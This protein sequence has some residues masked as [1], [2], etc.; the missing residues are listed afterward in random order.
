MEN[1]AALE[2]E[3]DV[4]RSASSLLAPST[5]AATLFIALLWFVLCRA[6]SVEWSG[7]EQYSYGWFVPFFAAYLFWLR[8]EDRPAP[9]SAA[10]GRV[11][12]VLLAL[13]AGL[14]VALLPVRAFEVVAPDWRPLAWLHACIVVALTLLLLWRA[15]GSRWVRHFA[16]PVA[17]ILVAV[18]W[19]ATLETAVVQGLMRIVAAIAAESLALFGVPAQ[20][21][22]NLLRLRTGL[23]GVDEACS[24]VRSLQ[25]SFM[26]GLLFGELHRLR[27]LQRI[28][29]LALAA[30]VAFVGNVCRAFFLVWVAAQHGI[31]A[32]ERWHDLTGFSIVIIVFLGTMAAASLL[33]RKKEEGGASVAASEPVRQGGRERCAGAAIQPLPVALACVWILLVEGGVEAWYRYHERG[34]VA[35]EKWTVQWPETARDFQYLKLGDG[36]KGVL[37]F[38]EGRGASWLLDPPP[39]AD[40]VSG[41]RPGA[42]APVTCVLY[43]FRWH[44]GRSSI[45]RARGHR[46]D[47]C[48]PSVGWRQSGDH[49]TR[50]YPTGELSLPFRHFEFVRGGSGSQPRFVAHAFF[51][52]GEETARPGTGGSETERE[53]R[54]THGFTMIPRL[55]RLVRSGE[56]PRGQQVMQLIFVSSSPLTAETAQAQHARL[57][58]FLVTIETAAPPR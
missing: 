47:V 10:A 29:L 55:W 50:L 53:I 12:L 58:D 6:L 35:R 52:V 56:R 1:S 36:L 45:L 51:C 13:A 42:G 43:F 38:D 39:E 14:L 8:W 20:L 22:G 49:G 11:P 19:I 34:F 32:T 2:Q 26:I 27:L 5:L 3:Q 31:D 25:S 28:T 4:G 16:F 40:S 48:L 15:G 57:V 46:P 9:V 23:V 7:N 37:R 30:S 33:R 18:P 17:F 44:A 41:L 21:E 54:E 24:G